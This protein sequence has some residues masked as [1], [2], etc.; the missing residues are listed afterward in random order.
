M[1]SECQYG[2]ETISIHA[3]QKADPTTGSSTVPIYQTAAYQFKDTEHAARLFSLEEYGN[4]Y[5]R[6]MNPTQ[7]AFEE[8]MARLEGGVGAL[9]LSSGQAATA[10][11]ILN[12]AHSGD[13][14]VVSS[15]LY[16]GTYTLFSLMLPRLGIHV[17]W[18]RAD[19]VNSFREAINEKTKAVFTEMIGNPKMDIPDIEALA[20]ITHSEGVPL[21]VDS[22]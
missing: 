2:F 17:R 14:I 22:T 12:V 21:I 5:T 9:A 13:E 8:C 19:D 16:G 4:V 11:S 7:A 3:G 20:E 10:Y 18:A 1:S 15:S 6:I